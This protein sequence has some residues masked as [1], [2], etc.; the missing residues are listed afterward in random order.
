M[1]KLIIVESPTKAKTINKLLGKDFVVI[2]SFG[3]IRDLPKNSMGIDIDNEFKPHYVIPKDKQK[4]VNTIKAEAKK[5][6]EILFATDEDREGEAIAWH[7]ATILKIKP[8]ESKRIVFHEITAEAIKTALKNPRQLDLNLVDAQQARRILDRLVG[9]ELS[10]FLWKKVARGLSAGRVQSVAVRLIVEREREIEKFT[11]QE[12][13][14][15]EAKL[16]SGSHEFIAKLLKHQGKTLDKFALKDKAAAQAI[17][18]ELQNKDFVVDQIISKESKKNP[19]PPFTTSSL[20]QAANRLLGFS[21]KQTMVIAQ[22]LYE[23]VKLGAAGEVGLITYM[24]TD[25]VNLADKFIDEAKQFI[26]TK[27]GAEFSSPTKYKTKSKGAQE[28]HEAIRPTAASRTP[29]E[30]KPYLD[31]NQFKL[32]RL[33]WQRAIASQMA[34]AII[35]QTAVDIKANDYIFRA[36]GSI[37]AFKGWLEVYPDKVNENLLPPLTEKEKLTLL[38]LKALQHFTQPPARY[39]EAALVKALE[40]KGIGRPSTYA[41]T[42]ATIQERNYVKKEEGKLIPTDIG[43]LVNNILVEH[44]PTI[45]DYDFTA[46]MEEQLDEIAQ[47]KI[48]WQP[49]ISAFYFPFKENLEKKLQELSKKDLTEQTTEEKCEKCGSPM[50]IKVGRFGKF[51]ACSNYPECKNTKHLNHN[52]EIEEP[53]TTEEKCEKCGSPMIIKVGRFGKFLA[54]SNY[55]ECKNT[56]PIINGTGVSCP[57]CQQGEVIIKKSKRGRQFF[58]CSRY[59]DCDFISWSKPT[60]DNCPLCQSHLVFAKGDQIIC[61]NKECDYSSSSAS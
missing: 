59:P 17:V 15:I 13:W 6:P 7:L 2:S 4:I 9:Y 24:R 60:G 30:V 53:E 54:C 31:S 27:F 46:K 34:A 1:K 18:E 22:Q 16:Q 47:G 49:V 41:P 28:A 36:N 45:V 3:H 61:S 14:T 58:S 50:I 23:G 55:P 32:Y 44:F 43:I 39:T 37:I 12:Y 5:Y 20:Q 19:Y 26:S 11:P 56:K 21:T 40:E 42:I 57:K 38:D 29:E 8:D 10:P 25:S 51:L 35:K 52:N 48:K 33:I